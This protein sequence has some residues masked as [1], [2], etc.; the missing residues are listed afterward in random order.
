[1][2][3]SRLNR[4]S[5]QLL[6]LLFLLL[7]LQWLM[8]QDCATKLENAKRSYY[9]GQFSQIEASLLPCLEKG[10][11]SVEKEE[12]LELLAKASVM[13]ENEA[14]AEEYM[15]Q[16]LSLNPLYQP[17]SSDLL[18]FAE[19]FQRFQVKTRFN[20]GIAAGFNLPDFTVMR[21]QSYASR[22][23]EPTAYGR[24][25]GLSAGIFGEYA[26]TQNIYLGTSALIQSHTL[27]QSEII[28]DYQEVSSSERYLYMNT[29]LV[30]K[31]QLN[32]WGLKPSL[33]AGIG[34]HTLLSATADI[35]LI[36]LAPEFPKAFIGSPQ[37]VE[38]FA[39]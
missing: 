33:E 38:D 24:E 5:R 3:R 14:K 22:T 11:N 4:V 15:L 39:V 8:G 27:H 26:L 12:A 9:N 36:P 1:M 17:R 29:P 37:S 7:P 30:V 13:I 10:F 23:I 6:M 28:L 32:R 2:K 31:Y 20:L 34:V 21:Y 16:L 35:S 19:L 18:D 25:T